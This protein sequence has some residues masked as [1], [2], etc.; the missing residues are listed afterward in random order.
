ME[1]WGGKKS[2]LEVSY[3]NKVWGGWGQFRFDLA[4]TPFCCNLWRN[5][6]L[7]WDRL[8]GHVT[9]VIGDC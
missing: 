4:T 6:K 7:G 3:L 2:P 9:F 1:I 5:K 8:A